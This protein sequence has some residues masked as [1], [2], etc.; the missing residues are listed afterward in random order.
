MSFPTFRKLR[1]K[2]PQNC[3]KLYN[4]IQQI[5]ILFGHFQIESGS[6]KSIIHKQL[7]MIPIHQKQ[8]D[9]K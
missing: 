9:I 6:V 3:Y 4:K 8:Q 2:K 1:K 5:H 7:L